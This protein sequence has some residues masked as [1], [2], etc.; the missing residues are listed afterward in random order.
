[1]WTRGQM[2][3]MRWMAS[4]GVGEGADIMDGKAGG[5]VGGIKR[6]GVL[7]FKRGGSVESLLGRIQ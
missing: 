2:K 3:R 6:K 5:R 1:M 7:V 4:A